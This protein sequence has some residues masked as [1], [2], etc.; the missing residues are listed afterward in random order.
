MAGKR[1]FQRLTISGCQTPP[2][3]NRARGWKSGMPEG[4]ADVLIRIHGV[5]CI[6]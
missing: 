3:H 2:A 1:P 6:A 4:E 5:V